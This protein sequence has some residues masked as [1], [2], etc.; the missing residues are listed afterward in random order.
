MKKALLILVGIFIS[1]MAFAD[2]F[3]KVKYEFVFGNEKT[4]TYQYAI[5]TDKGQF[6]EIT[7]KEN[8]IYE[9]MNVY[10]YTK[11]GN[12]YT[13]PTVTG[14]TMELERDGNDLV[15]RKTGKRYVRITDV[16][17]LGM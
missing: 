3:Y 5:L 9:Y 6:I 11:T 10:Q 14:L 15:L 8:G 17:L 1:S 4:I 12:K 13:M 2:E 16:N 7:F